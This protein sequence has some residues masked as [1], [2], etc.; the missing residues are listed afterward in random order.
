MAGAYGNV[1]AATFLLIYSLTDAATFF[2]VI[3]ISC[4]VVLGLIAVFLD[5]PAGHI[6]E[7]NDDGT[8]ELIQ[9][10]K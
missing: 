2:T 10:G 3:S 6:A 9:V 8:V 1:G 5:E 4:A 7:I